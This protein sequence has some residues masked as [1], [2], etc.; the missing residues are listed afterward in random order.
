MIIGEIDL[1]GAKCPSC[2]F[3]IVRSING[4]LEKK[5]HSFTGLEVESTR[6]ILDLVNHSQMKKSKDIQ[7]CEKEIG[8]LQKKLIKR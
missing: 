3:K 4:I 2:Q 8:Q 1:I 5:L 6:I 7:N